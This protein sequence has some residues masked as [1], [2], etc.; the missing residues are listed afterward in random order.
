MFVFMTSFLE[1]PELIVWRI[2]GYNLAFFTDIY[3]APKLWIFTE[4]FLRIFRDLIHDFKWFLSAI[5][6]YDLKIHQCSDETADVEILKF[7]V[8]VSLDLNGSDKA[9]LSEIRA[10]MVRNISRG[11]KYGIWGISRA[12][13]LIFG[14]KVTNRV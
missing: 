3:S 13:T 10:R 7:W 12:R 11:T 5:K 2:S 6:S 1:F 4:F 9:G 8:R 14:I